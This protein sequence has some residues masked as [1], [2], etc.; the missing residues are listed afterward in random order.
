MAHSTGGLFGEAILLHGSGVISCA[1]FELW[2]K[3]MYLAETCRA[4]TNFNFALKGL[5]DM[6]FVR[7]NFLLKEN[8]DKLNSIDIKQVSMRLVSPY[9]PFYQ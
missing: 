4:R 8:S 6:C 7:L 2:L 5:K 1:C 3:Y 9:L